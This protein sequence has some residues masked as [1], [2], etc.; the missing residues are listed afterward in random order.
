M[1][2]KESMENIIIAIEKLTMSILSLIEHVDILSAHILKDDG[3]K[4][5]IESRTNRSH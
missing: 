2:D 5:G 4:N 3:Y 1:K